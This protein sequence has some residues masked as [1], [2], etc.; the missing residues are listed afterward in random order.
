MGLIYPGESKYSTAENSD[1]VPTDAVDEFFALALQIASSADLR[2]SILELFK[3][4][5]ASFHGKTYSSSSSYNWAESDL[6]SLMQEC[7]ERAPT[8][9]DAYWTSVSKTQQTGIP[10]PGVEYLNSIL[11]KHGIPYVIGNSRSC[12]GFWSQ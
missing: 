4:H 3:S 10:T 9:I 8:F 5:S 12:D 11:T 1:V 7:A 2:K 6:S